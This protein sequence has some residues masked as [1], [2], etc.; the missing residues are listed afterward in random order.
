MCFAKSCSSS[1]VA[2]DLKGVFAVLTLT[3]FT[4][5]VHVVQAF[6]SGRG[7]YTQPQPLM[8]DQDS[9]N[10][11]SWPPSSPG[12][13]VSN[14]PGADGSD[15]GSNVSTSNRGPE[16]SCSS[17]YTSSIQSFDD[18]DMAEGDYALPVPF[19]M[20]PLNEALPMT[21]SSNANSSSSNPAAAAAASIHSLASGTSLEGLWA[22]A[23]Q[24]TRDVASPADLL[25]SRGLWQDMREV[26]V[27]LF[28]VGQ[29]DTE[30]IYSLR[31]VSEDGLP[32]ET[33]IA[34]E[35]MDDAVR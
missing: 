29:K 28:G 15:G 30:G 20:Q 24:P 2:G 3:N 25:G 31:A 4:A 13:G 12:N 18:W 1:T 8:W 16:A 9:I 7:R 23:M 6:V 21:S 11:S 19:S 10:S 22:A 35:D 17:R 33:I 34:F 26:Y 14:V 5:L 32:T 27:L